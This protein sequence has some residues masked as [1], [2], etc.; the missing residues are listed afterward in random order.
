MVSFT[1]FVALFLYFICILYFFFCFNSSYFAQ[2]LSTEILLIL[3][4][5]Y[6]L[7]CQIKTESATTHCYVV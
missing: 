7:L 5:I 6:L 3:L 1:A 2:E 4:I